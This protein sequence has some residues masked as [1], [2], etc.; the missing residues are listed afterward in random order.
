MEK[1]CNY[2][3]MMCKTAAPQENLRNVR[4]MSYLYCPF[5]GVAG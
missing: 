5:Q 3:I 4:D 2:A 1:L